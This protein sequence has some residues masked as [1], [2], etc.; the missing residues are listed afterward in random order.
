MPTDV[1]WKRPFRGLGNLK[2][3]KKFTSGD[4]L[5][6]FAYS[7]LLFSAF[8]FVIALGH[9]Y[10][11][12]GILGLITIAYYELNALHGRFFT[13]NQVSDDEAGASDFQPMPSPVHKSIHSASRDTIEFSL[14]NGNLVMEKGKT[15]NS[16]SRVSTVYESTP[17]NTTK[18]N[19]N[20]VFDDCYRRGK[21]MGNGLDSHSTS[22]ESESADGDRRGYEVNKGLN[23]GKEKGVR[24]S[25]KTRGKT[26]YFFSKTH[27]VLS[28]I[29]LES[30]CLIVTF[31]GICVPWVIPRMIDTNRFI[32]SLCKLSLKY[33]YLATFIF[34]LMGIIKFILSVEKGRYK[35]N[36]LK[37]ALIIISLLYVVSQSLMIISNIYFGM[38]WLLL[39]HCLIILNDCLAYLFGRILGKKPLIVMSPKKTVE[40]FLY[41]SLFTI[42]IA[43]LVTPYLL[44]I[45]PL[46]CNAN[47]FTFVPFMYLRTECRVPYAYGT[48][49]FPTINGYSLTVDK[50]YVHVFVLSLFASL[51]A[52]F[53]G[54]LASGFKRA[55]KIKD[56]SNFIPGHGGILD[57]FDCHIL[58]GSFTY[59]YLKTFVR[60]TYPNVED[61]FKMVIKLQKADQVAVLDKI[62]EILET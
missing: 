6:R 34:A 15:T 27:D 57:R 60:K 20:Q 30:Y 9:M 32:R 51:F 49:T 17:R 58:M 38:I 8:V 7:V 56:F 13:L 24:Q 62:N 61:V 10:C 4:F 22:Q 18:Q 26:T 46:L 1:D 45:K 29:S 21:Y 40:G 5:V 42:I 52:P 16:F 33:H 43:M 28:F 37:L 14:D 55:L 39:P 54:F 3:L 48:F 35:Q 44:K 41:S 36:F 19:S 31:L 11:A 50:M 25:R 47:K 59:L 23:T 12:I 53:G 2:Y